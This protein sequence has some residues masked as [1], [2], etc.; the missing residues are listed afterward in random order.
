MNNSIKG[1]SKFIEE[2]D[3]LI[4][5]YNDKAYIYDNG[6]VDITKKGMIKTVD[7]PNKKDA[8]LYMMRTG[9]KYA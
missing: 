9:W 3:L 8:V 7:F 4:T 6:K 1:K 5:D 2:V